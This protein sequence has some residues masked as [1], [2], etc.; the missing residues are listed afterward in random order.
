[1]FAKYKEKEPTAWYQLSLDTIVSVRWEWHPRRL[2]ASC[3]TS[4]KF[5]WLESVRRYFLQPFTGDHLY[6]TSA[7]V[8]S[9]VARAHARTCVHVRIPSYVSRTCIGG[10][11]GGAPRSSV[12]VHRPC[13]FYEWLAGYVIPTRAT[14]ACIRVT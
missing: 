6:N 11:E 2:K 8:R 9:R 13:Y 4:V 10:R 12:H 3:A 14:T 5:V 7:T 1:M